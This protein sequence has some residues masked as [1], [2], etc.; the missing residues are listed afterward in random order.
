MQLL[1]DSYGT[2]VHLGERECS[3]QRRHQKLIEES[4]CVALAPAVREQ[5]LTTAVRG[6]QAM[7]YTSAGTMEFLVQGDEF[8]FM[9][10]NTRIQVEHPVTEMVT[11][12]DLIKEMIAVAAGQPADDLLSHRYQLLVDQQT[13]APAQVYLPDIDGVVAVCFSADVVCAYSSANFPVTK[14]RPFATLL[15]KVR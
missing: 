4:P 9:E 10:M 3:V 1:G 14:V 8:Y 11:G 7:H 15:S 5:L 2:I 13:H 12:R 6:A